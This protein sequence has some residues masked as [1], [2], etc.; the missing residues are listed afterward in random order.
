MNFEKILF[1]LYNLF[2]QLIRTFLFF[3]QGSYS[4]VSVTTAKYFILI[5]DL[6]N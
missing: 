3:I 2:M 5:K 1:K 4:I 6:C